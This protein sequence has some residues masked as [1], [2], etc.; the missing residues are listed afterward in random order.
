MAGA[1]GERDARAHL[2]RERAARAPAAAEAMAKRP[3]AQAL[4]LAD[5][6]ERELERIAGLRAQ[7]RQD[8]ADRA[9]AEFRKRYPDFKISEEV[10]VRVE[11]R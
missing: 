4:S 10:R 7:G 1:L 9:L 8:E 3:E 2:S 11:R 6:P 5:T